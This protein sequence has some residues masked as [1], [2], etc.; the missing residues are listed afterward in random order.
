MSGAPPAALQVN[1]TQAGD[2][3]TFPQKGQTVTVHYTGRLISNGTKFDSSVDRGQPFKFTIGVG[4]VIRGW[5]E[6]VAQMSVGQ[7]ATLRIPSAMGTTVRQI[8]PETSQISS[9]VFKSHSD[10]SS[11]FLASHPG[12]GARG[13]GGVIPAN[14]DLEFDV[15]VWSH[16]SFVIIG[17]QFLNSWFER[18][19]VLSQL[20]AI[21]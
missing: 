10:I 11:F 8:A 15:E 7:K 19:I 20:I 5:D 17:N 2:G 6:G 3:K 12:Y 21:N 14:A 9:Q 16:T 4:Q 1:T 18:F 13:A